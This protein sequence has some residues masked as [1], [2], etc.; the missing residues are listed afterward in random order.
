MKRFLL[1]LC[2]FFLLA[3]AAGAE[4]MPYLLRFPL[5]EDAKLISGT[6]NFQLYQFGTT[7][8]NTS[9]YRHTEEKGFEDYLAEAYPT[10]EEIDL[11]KTVDVDGVDAQCA[12]F[13]FLYENESYQ[14]MSAFLNVDDMD[15]LVLIDCSSGNPS[16]GEIETMLDE[17]QLYSAGFKY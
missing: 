1:F 11:F 7:I 5:P 12:R 9:S 10:H 3:S 14:V 13:S 6:A 2:V 15:Y 17:L 8:L 4:E 16:A